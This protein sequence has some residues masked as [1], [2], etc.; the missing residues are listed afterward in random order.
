MGKLAK[1]CKSVR[2]LYAQKGE[3]KERTVEGSFQS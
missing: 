3:Y 1:I 2:L